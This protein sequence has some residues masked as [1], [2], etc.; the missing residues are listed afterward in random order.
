VTPEPPLSP[1]EH[2][3][4][5]ILVGGAITLALMGLAAMYGG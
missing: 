4:I 5:A 1:H 2:I 3:A